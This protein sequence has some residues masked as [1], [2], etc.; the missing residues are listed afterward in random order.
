[1]QP[2]A[3]CNFLL[4]FQLTK[5]QQGGVVLRCDFDLHPH[6]SSQSF[7]QHNWQKE[8]LAKSG[9]G[10]HHSEFSYLPD[11]KPAHFSGKKLGD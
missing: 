8:L 10:S 3:H 11:F 9:H 7:S 1:M 2:L 4:Q 5:K 6:I